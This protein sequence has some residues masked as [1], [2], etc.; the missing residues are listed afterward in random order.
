MCVEEFYTL[1][2]QWGAS[3]FIYEKIVLQKLSNLIKISQLLSDRV[4]ILS[5]K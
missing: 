5:S 4:R 1:A 2:T 3:Y